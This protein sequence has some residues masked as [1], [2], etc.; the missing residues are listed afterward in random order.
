MSRLAELIAASTPPLWLAADAYAGRLLANDNPPW[1]DSAE[2]IAWHRKATSLLKPGVA[3][4]AVAPVVAAWIDHDAATLE[5]MRAKRRTVAPLKNLLASE[6]LRA[7][8]QAILLG[9]RASYAGQPLALVVP[10]PHLWLVLA[11]QAA[12]DEVPEYGEDEIDNAAMYLADF[13]RSFGESGIDL[14]LL[15]ETAATEPAS[16]AALELYQAAL[17]VAGHFRWGVGLHLPQGAHADLA[18]AGF[19]FVIA[20]VATS[21]KTQGQAQGAAFWQDSAAPA[22]PA[23][24]FHF[25]EIPADATPEHVLTR[26]ATLR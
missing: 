4:F 20:P 26:L 16:D 19:D 25:T 21:A 15:D 9:L 10:S 23:N 12:F 11:Y 3:A 17:N 24:G 5:A 7:H 1:L 6:G 13:L 14:L 2:Y 22:L 8:L 18:F